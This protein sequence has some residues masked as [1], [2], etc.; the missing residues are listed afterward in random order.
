MLLRAKGATCPSSQLVWVS[1]TFGFSWTNGVPRPVGFI[2]GLGWAVSMLAGGFTCSIIWRDHQVQGQS[3]DGHQWKNCA[4]NS[5]TSVRRRLGWRMADQGASCRHLGSC[6]SIHKSDVFTSP[7]KS[8]CTKSPCL[9]FIPSLTVEVQQPH[10][11]KWGLDR[12]SLTTAG[13]QF[14]YV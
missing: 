11:F 3:A 6:D 1:R 9:T 5:S 4:R 14:P 7:R 13:T 12:S 10:S 2:H 8:P